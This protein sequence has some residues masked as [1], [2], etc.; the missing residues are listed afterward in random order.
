MSHV[1]IFN[2]QTT[3]CQQKLAE[4]AKSPGYDSALASHCVPSAAAAKPP[5]AASQPPKAGGS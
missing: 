3:L 5:S 2:N 4:S 1:A